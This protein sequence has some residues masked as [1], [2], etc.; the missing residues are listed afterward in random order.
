MGLSVDRLTAIMTDSDKFELKL[1]NDPSVLGPSYL[2]DMIATCR[3]YTNSVVQLLNEISRARMDVGRDLRRRKT[4]F[5]IAS[6][7]LLAKDPSVKGLP[8]IKDRE[9]QINLLLKEERRILENLDNDLVDHTHVEEYLKRRHRELKDTMRE[10]Q[11]QRSLMQDDRSLGG[12][13]GDE[14]P[15]DQEKARAFIPG[16]SASAP[17]GI[18][19]RDL[20]NALQTGVGPSD[21]EPV[22]EEASAVPM[23]VVT[24]TSELVTTPVEPPSTETSKKESPS[25]EE[26]QIRDFLEQG[27][28]KSSTSSSSDSSTEDSFDDILN[29]L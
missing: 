29:S 18:S 7:E 10:I 28:P 26:D 11:T 8:N 17:E 5:K 1:A 14:R 9:A 16:A 6:D 25:S 4:A 19:E 21:A 15:S 12:M 27:D 24:K 3:N 13:Y 20:E 22:S 23:T 2:Q